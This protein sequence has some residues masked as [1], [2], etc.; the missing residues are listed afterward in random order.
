MLC[1]MVLMY[2]FSMIKLL[3]IIKIF[4]NYIYKEDKIISFIGILFMVT[5]GL[6]INLR[7]LPWYL[8]LFF[9]F[10]PITIN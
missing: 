9:N 4:V 3:F 5:V 10:A 1:F 8:Q 6:Q 7:N 2:L